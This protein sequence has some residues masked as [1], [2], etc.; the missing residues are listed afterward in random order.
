MRTKIVILLSIVLSAVLIVALGFYV[1]LVLV[2]KD[3]VNTSYVCI[4]EEKD[5]FLLK[6]YEIYDEEFKMNFNSFTIYDK[7]SQKELFVCPDK[8][9]SYDLHSIGFDKYSY[10][11][12]VATGDMGDI[13][14]KYNDGVWEKL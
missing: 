9:R 5:G 10:D 14:Y 2:N 4:E 1:C 13:I 7:N 8:F 3:I 11:V 6:T 12:I